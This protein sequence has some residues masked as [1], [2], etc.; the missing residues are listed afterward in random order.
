MPLDLNVFWC[1]KPRAHQ[2]S[3]QRDCAIYLCF[4]SGLTRAV[5]KDSSGDIDVSTLF[6]QDLIYVQ[7]RHGRD[8][9][10]KTLVLTFK[11]IVK[12]DTTFMFL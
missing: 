8:L 3:M 11:L 4:K 12:L 2:D 7:A 10:E 9:A 5:D 1:V 6:E